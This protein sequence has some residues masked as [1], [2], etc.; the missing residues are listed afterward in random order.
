[1]GDLS[2]HVVFFNGYWYLVFEENG[3]WINIGEREVS[4]KVG[5]ENKILELP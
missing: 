1:M 4:I 2:T 3:Y 5:D